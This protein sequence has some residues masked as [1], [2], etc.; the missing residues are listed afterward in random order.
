MV[1]ICWKEG[2]PGWEKEKKKRGKEIIDK[3]K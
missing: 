1:E 3:S 2:L